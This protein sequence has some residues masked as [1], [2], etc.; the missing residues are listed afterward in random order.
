MYKDRNR[1]PRQPA[2]TSWQGDFQE[3][4]DPP[5]AV[6]AASTGSSSPLTSHLVDF[7]RVT[8]PAVA[9]D[10]ERRSYKSSP[11]RKPA[12]GLRLP[13]A[14]HAPSPTF[15]ENIVSLRSQ[16]RKIVYSNVTFETSAFPFLHLLYSLSFS[17]SL[18][19]L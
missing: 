18:L 8:L 2:S 4:W 15:W 14:S 17:L 11:G 10:R 13:T 6:L 1:L 12:T 16:K 19:R 3:G 5:T 9:D 7:S